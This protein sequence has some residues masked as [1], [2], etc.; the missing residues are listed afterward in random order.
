M[1]IL[2]NV[3]LGAVFEYCVVGVVE[4]IH[5]KLHIRLFKVKNMGKYI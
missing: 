2:Y 1:C 4:H 3:H 5:E